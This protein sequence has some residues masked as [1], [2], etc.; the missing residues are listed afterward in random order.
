MALPCIRRRGWRT[1]WASRASPPACPL[2]GLFRPVFAVY[3]AVVF[4]LV[5]LGSYV[6]Y[7]SRMRETQAALDALIDGWRAR[8]PTLAAWFAV[9]RLRPSFVLTEPVDG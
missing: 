8:V 5:A 7:D 9:W 4:A 6:L 1:I 3:A 2:R